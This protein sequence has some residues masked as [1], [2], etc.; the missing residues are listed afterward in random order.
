M[1]GQGW[2]HTRLILGHF[3]HGMLG[4]HWHHLGLLLSNFKAILWCALA[5]VGK[6]WDHIGSIF[7]HIELCWDI[8]SRVGTIL[9][10]D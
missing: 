8:L 7:G 4:Q 2:D 5:F 1:L 10:S 6:S 9:G 3:G